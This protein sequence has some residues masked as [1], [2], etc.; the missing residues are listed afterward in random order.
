MYPNDKVAGIRLGEK[1]SQNHYY[2]ERSYVLM[3]VLGG[4]DYLVSKKVSDEATDINSDVDIVKIKKLCAKEEVFSVICSHQLL[5]QHAG[6]Q[7]TWESL[8][9]K[10]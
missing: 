8:K 3:K 5:R 1:K 6:A 10:L 7:T 4:K 9:K 2:I